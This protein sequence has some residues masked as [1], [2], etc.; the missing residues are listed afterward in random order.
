[1]KKVLIVL[2]ALFLA[3]AV[4][5]YFTHA[6]FGEG[7]GY[8]LKT[9]LE[10][11]FD[12]AT[13]VNFLA[14]DNSGGAT[15]TVAPGDT[16]YL[17]LKTWNEGILPG[18]NTAFTGTFT[19]QQYLTNSTMFTG[20]GG[21]SGDLDGD[22]VNGYSM[23]GGGYNADTGVAEFGLNAVANGST[24]DVDFQSGGI[25]SQI[26]ATTP[27]QT[28]ILVTVVVTSSNPVALLD[29]LLPR[30]YAD[31]FGTTQVRIL[32]ND[33]ANDATAT[34]TPTVTVSSEATATETA[35]ESAALPETGA[36]LK[37]I[38]SPEDIK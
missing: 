22:T 7:G 20:D 3:L 36:D 34:P 15:L 19:N 1:M 31:A 25:T 11:S 6:G 14:E 24:E 4:P 8:N 13:W 27:D 23:I 17:R 10:V 18:A 29:H 5:V 9:R 30:A 16:I 26:A 33:P 38:L 35:L 37:M 28:V 12:N 2:G 32:V 21:G